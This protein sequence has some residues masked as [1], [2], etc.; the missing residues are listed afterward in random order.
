MLPKHTNIKPQMKSRIPALS[1][2]I[3]SLASISQGAITWQTPQNI[4]GDSD[5]STNGTSL[6]AINFRST[7]ITTQV[8]GV[9]FTNA[10]ALSIAS[11]RFESLSPSTYH[12]SPGG[13]ETPAGPNPAVGHTSGSFAALSANYQ[14][15][16]NQYARSGGGSGAGLA[17]DAAFNAWSLTMNGLV[18]GN[19]YEVQIWINDS[20]DVVSAYNGLGTLDRGLGGPVVDYNVGNVSGGGGLGQYVVGTFVA[21][22][23]DE[24]FTFDTW[25]APVSNVG[26]LNAFQVRVIPEPSAALLGVLGLSGFALRRRR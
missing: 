2:C 5:I 6:Y 18:A 20:R 15:L 7:G 26:A 11:Y 4:T 19:T 14:N 17:E 25:A 12:Q 9:T 13:T 24:L 3:L 10:T 1:A 8:N 22:G 16:L 23:S 21:T